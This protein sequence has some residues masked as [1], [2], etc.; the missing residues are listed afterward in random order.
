MAWWL[1]RE[2]LRDRLWDLAPL[3]LCLGLI[4]AAVSLA[5]PAF[6]GA[7]FA[8]VCAGLG[9]LAGYGIWRWLIDRDARAVAVDPGGP[10]RAA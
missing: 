9:S 2:F 1:F 8:A 4:D 3:I 10:T 6:P 7:R 5:T